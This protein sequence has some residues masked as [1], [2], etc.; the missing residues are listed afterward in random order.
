MILIIFDSM[1]NDDKWDRIYTALEDV[2]R[3]QFLRERSFI[4]EDGLTEKGQSLL[5]KM[6][7]IYKLTNE[8]TTETK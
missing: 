3:Y 8:A 1:Q 7:E 5:R 2:K 6:E 4:D